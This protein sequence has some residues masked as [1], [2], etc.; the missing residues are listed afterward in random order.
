[1]QKAYNFVEWIFIEQVLKLLGFPEIFVKWIMAYLCSVLYSVLINGKPTVPFEAKKGLRQGDPLS[2]FL[3]VMAME[4][5]S[6]LLKPLKENKNFKF[7]PKCAKVNL[8]QL[9][10]AD[11]LLLFCEGDLQSV[12]KQI[13][14]LLGYSKGDLPFRYLGV[15]LSTKRLTDVQCEP[16]I[17]KMQGRVQNWTTKFLSYAGRVT[18]VKS[19]LFVVQT[20]WAQ[21]FILPKKIIQFIEDICRIFLWIGA[22]EPTKIGKW[23][24]LLRAGATGG[25]TLTAPNDAR[26]TPRPLPRPRRLPR[27]RPLAPL[28]TG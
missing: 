16:L 4:Y 24:V 21:V 7:H 22:V 23:F 14:K 20:F 10:F 2:L 28:T 8:V 13:M 18:L 1:M 5:L 9:G 11:D 17:D 6:R 25:D 27:P 12:H 19:V 26:A 3:F 15:P